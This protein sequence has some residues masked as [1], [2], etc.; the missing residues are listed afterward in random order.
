MTSGSEGKVRTE[1]LQR[2][3][4]LYIR[5]STLRQVMENTESTKRQYAMRQRAVALG[6]RDEQ[7]V[8]IDRDLGKS[9]A[10][11]A[12][13]EG[14]QQLVTEVGLGRAGIVMG[15][16]VSR[17]ARRSSDWHR[18]VEIC[19]LRHT[20]ILDEDGLYDP[21]DFNDRLLL[22]LKG[23]MS[24]AELHF[25][26]ARLNGGRMN[27]VARGEYRFRLPAGFV[28]DGQKRVTLDPDGQVQQVIRTFFETYRR[29]GTVYRT[30][31]TFREQGLRFPTR[32]HFGPCKGE[33]VWGQLTTSRAFVLLH[34]PRYAGAYAYGRRQQYPIDA[35]GRV[36]V[37]HEPRERW[38][39]LMLGAHAG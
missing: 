38:H 4:Y 10:S 25:I 27:A 18:L 11:A 17:L 31:K 6:W 28:Y 7:V 35:D 15:L 34:N 29:V 20:L 32:M 39:T 14:F 24:E 1:H 19:A 3:A 2:Q 8:V 36:A 13:R 5:Q 9:A 23:T 33:L 22:G 37:K 26:R 30:V 12:D 16:E 21:G